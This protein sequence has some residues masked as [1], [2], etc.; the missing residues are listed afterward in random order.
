MMFGSVGGDHARATPTAPDAAWCRAARGNAADQRHACTLIAHQAIPEAVALKQ[1]GD[2][3][4]TIGTPLDT[5]PPWATRESLLATLRAGIRRFDLDVFAAYGSEAGH[6]LLIGHPG[7][8]QSAL[9]LARPPTQHTA[10]EIAAMAEHKLWPPPLTLDELLAW[11]GTTAAGQQVESITLEPKQDE[12]IPESAFVKM[13]DN[14]I[15]A[16]GLDSRTTI[17]LR[18]VGQHIITPP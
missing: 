16:P 14:V 18:S 9:G 13:L 4:N 11:M 17:I 15:R 1:G 10:G 6:S 2:R 8:V 12:S 7:Q 3:A 5:S